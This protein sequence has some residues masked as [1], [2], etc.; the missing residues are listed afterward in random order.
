MEK[1]DKLKLAIIQPDTDWED[2]D[3]NRF[4]LTNAISE[5][6]NGVD[7]VIMPEVF[8][9]GFTM[10]AAKVAEEMQGPT[11]SWMK[12]V[13]AERDFA[14]CGSLIVKDKGL[15][16]NRFVWVY[17]NG[18]MHT[19]DKSH[20]F[21]I[22]KETENFTKGNSQILIEYKGWKIFPIVCY[23]VRFPEW[24]RN[25]QGYDLMINVANWPAVRRKV[26]DVLNRARAIENQS[27][28]V[29]V[30]RVGR[31]GA[32][33]NY[34]GDSMVINFKGKRILKAKNE[35]GVFI[36]SISKEKL[37]A[38]RQKFNT[39]RDADDFKLL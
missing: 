25:T 6:P 5:I 9:S 23:D 34:S 37:N 36:K 2:A 11:V 3:S 39:L 16:Y 13:A 28:V 8:V 26:W 27:Y 12:K 4:L 19:Y 32:L 18:E 14:L 7:L 33:I 38:F 24:T 21:T 15:Y 22:E 35:E 29:A 30:N 1:K 20:L 31:D 10:N 17:P